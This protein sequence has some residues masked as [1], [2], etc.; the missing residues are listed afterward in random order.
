MHNTLNEGMKKILIEKAIEALPNAH[1]PYSNFKVASAA[2][3]SSGRIYVGVNMET[4]SFGGTICAERNAIST[5]VSAG[6][7]ALVAI[8]IVGGPDGDIT[9][10]YC[11][12]CGICRQTMIDFAGK[13]DL[14]VIC[15]K[16]PE[17]YVEYTL[18]DLLPNSFGAD[19]L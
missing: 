16:S 3:M 2:L 15:A 6:E 5:A 14:I 12:P 7:R 8:A 17:D 13:D 19:F 10:K 18:G 1:A 4:S 11:A 9:K